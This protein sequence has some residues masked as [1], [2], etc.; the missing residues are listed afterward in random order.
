MRFFDQQTKY[1][2]KT[3]VAPTPRLRTS[4][5]VV[6]HAA[7]E[8]ERGRACQSIFSYH[9]RKWPKYGRIGYHVVLQEEL[10][11]GIGYHLVNPLRI[12]GANVLKRNHEV[13]GICCATNFTGLPPE[14]WYVALVEGLRHLRRWY[15]NAPIVG[16][17]DV[18]LPEGRTS[19]PGPRWLEWRSR[20]LS[21]VLAAR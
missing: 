14:K 3:A 16:H 10:D 11:G 20:L 7:F 18:A 21:D 19:C 1:V 5:I 17:T 6:H 8:Y 2:A 15:P 4:Y 12:Q 13:V 9:S